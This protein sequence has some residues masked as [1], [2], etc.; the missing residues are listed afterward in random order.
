[1]LKSKHA[2]ALTLVRKALPDE[3]IAECV[4]AIMEIEDNCQ[5]RGTNLTAKQIAAEAIKLLNQPF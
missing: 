4:M 3:E 1:M 5:E 2:T